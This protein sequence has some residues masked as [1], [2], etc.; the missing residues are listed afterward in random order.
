MGR[1]GGTRGLGSVRNAGV[2]P[3]CGLEEVAMG[4][5]VEKARE[6][7]AVIPWPSVRSLDFSPKGR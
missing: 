1:P 3:G 4:G 6:A 2:P 5:G 7:K